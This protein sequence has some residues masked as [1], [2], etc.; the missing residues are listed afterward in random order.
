MIFLEI[1]SAW[2]IFDL[3]VFVFLYTRR[4][5]PRHEMPP[6]LRRAL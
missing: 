1:L 4:P 2:L 5:T 6:Y 3:V